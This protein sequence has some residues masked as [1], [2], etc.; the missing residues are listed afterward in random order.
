MIIA[1]TVKRAIAFYEERLIHLQF[2]KDIIL[3]EKIV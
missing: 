2:K 1:V 3:E